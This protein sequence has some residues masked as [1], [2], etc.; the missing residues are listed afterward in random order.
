MAVKLL[1]GIAGANFSHAPGE[2]VDLDKDTEKRLV[3]SGQAEKVVAKK[4]AAKKK[5]SK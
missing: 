4:K 2:V 1:T 5:T 3:D